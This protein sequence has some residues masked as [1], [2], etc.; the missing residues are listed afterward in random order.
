M[1]KVVLVRPPSIVSAGSFSG[2]LTPP[3]GLAYLAS[4]LRRYDHQV[5]IVDSVGID[6][7]KST[8]LGDKLILRG[9]NFSEI[10]DLIPKDTDLIGFSGMFSSE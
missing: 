8:Y 1:T 3:I 2:F 4:A 9:I 5:T 6:P 10:L 7:D